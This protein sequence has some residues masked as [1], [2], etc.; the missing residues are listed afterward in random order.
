MTADPSIHS[1]LSSVSMEDCEGRLP[2]FGD[3]HISRGNRR[4]SIPS[5]QKSITKSRTMPYPLY[6]ECCENSLPN[7]RCSA[8][9]LAD[10]LKSSPLYHQQESER[11]GQA[12][13]YYQE[14]MNNRDQCCTSPP[15]S[16]VNLET[17]HKYSTCGTSFS[18]CDSPLG[19]IDNT[20]T[21][22]SLNGSLM[23]SFPSL[24][25]V[26]TKNRSLHGT[27]PQSRGDS[28]L[29]LEAV[30]AVHELSFA[31]KTISVSEILPR[32]PD[33]IFVNVTTVEGQPYC[34]ELTL[35]GWRVT[36]L[37]HDCM[38]GDY[39]RLDLFTVYYDTLY[40]LMDK[41]SPDYRNL[42]S[43]KLAQ[44]LRMLQA[45][46]DDD[47]TASLPFSTAILST[48]MTN[49]L[50]IETPICH[51]TSVEHSQTNDIISHDGKDDNS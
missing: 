7:S 24:T 50:N 48:N 4:R 51:K 6:N 26:S 33:L 39:T 17:F 45:A 38:Q 16:P 27:N 31:V 12:I 28:S 10:C 41:L 18:A 44:K 36:S 25:R 35:K 49:N 8:N 37:R 47:P 29:E 15:N 30:A 22:G 3:Y 21:I 13:N 32:T 2:Y 23:G 43:E 20:C 5:N 34:L 42:F 14:M 1:K 9:V 19:D 40:D 11:W 46:E